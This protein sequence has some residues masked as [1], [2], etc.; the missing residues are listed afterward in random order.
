MATVRFALFMVIRCQ[1]FEV[2]VRVRVRVR[3]G[4]GLGLGFGQ[5]VITSAAG[6]LLFAYLLQLRASKANFPQFLMFPR[7]CAH[8]IG[9]RR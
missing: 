6:F 4:L 2:R 8:I 9:R 3:F 5:K 1:I 7:S